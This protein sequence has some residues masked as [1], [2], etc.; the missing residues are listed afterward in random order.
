MSQEKKDNRVIIQGEA[1]RNKLLE[2]ARAAYDA[3]TS[4]YG[5]RGRNVM[6]EK[7]F[8][9]PVLTRDGVTVSRDV[10]FS[11]RAKNMGAQTVMEASETTNRIAG[12]GTTAT[13]ALSYHLIHNGSKAIA[14]GSHPMEVR[15]QLLKDREEILNKLSELTKDVKE[16]QLRSV[17]TVSSG[18]PILGE[19][20]ADAVQY[21][22]KDGGIITEKSYV[23]D[24]ERDYVDG[25]YLQS[26]FDALPTGK[27]EIVKPSV[28]VSTRRLSSP[29]DAIELLNQAAS[30]LGVERTPDGRQ[31]TI[32]RFL[33]IG[34]IEEGA[35]HTIVNTINQGVIDAIIIKTPPMFGSMGKDLLEDIAMYAGCEPVSDSTIIEDFNAE[36]IG[37]VDKVVAGKLEATLFNQTAQKE[38]ISRVADLKS[39]IEEEVSEA[40][41]E[42]LKDRVAKLEGKVA[43]FRIGGATDT[44]KEEK[45]F[46]VE[47][48]IQATR[49]AF[50]NGVVAGG[51]VTLLELSK[52]DVSEVFKISLR[53]MFKQLLLNANLSAEVKLA[54]ALEAK[55]GHGY[56]LRKGDELVDVVKEGI[57][58]P[59]LVVEQVIKNATSVATNAL[60]TDTLIT[61]EDK[62]E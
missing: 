35:Y 62:V 59:A 5:P 39:Q 42:K 43:L 53:E 10:Y 9:R 22:G 4:T 18:D 47:D 23:S 45:E 26:G 41:I 16:D 8:G 40:I 20:I 17:A 54:Q 15:D 38:V 55:T 44:E 6:L 3:V 2:G 33:F 1:A 25:Y 34:N 31:T 58:D 50:S 27:K 12:D 49:A 56:N 32:P 21:V 48:A 46:R 60:T 37:S 7:T 11:D 30:V 13:I 29:Q 28:I 24:I 14:N 36:Y 61:F 52:L 19:L 51:G 57:L